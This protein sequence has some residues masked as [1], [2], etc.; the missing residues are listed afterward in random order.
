MVFQGSGTIIYRELETTSMATQL[1]VM[2]RKWYLKMTLCTLN[3]EWS[4]IL[5]IVQKLTHMN[6]LFSVNKTHTRKKSPS[7]QK[8]G[9][10]SLDSLNKMEVFCSQGSQS[11][12]TAKTEFTIRTKHLSIIMPTCPKDRPLTWEGLKTILRKPVTKL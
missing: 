12:S 5:M 8:T 7:S 2:L 1:Q 11:T 3:K 9:T 4:P 6:S 10:L